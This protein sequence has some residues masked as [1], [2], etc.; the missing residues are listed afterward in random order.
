MVLQL[1]ATP[2]FQRL[3]QSGRDR[4]SLFG[5]PFQQRQIESFRHFGDKIPS[6]TSRISFREYFGFL[7]TRHGLEPGHTSNL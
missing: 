4:P 5:G 6:E 1:G 2:G 7:G 3:E